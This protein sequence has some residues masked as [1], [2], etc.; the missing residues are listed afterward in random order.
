MGRKVIGMARNAVGPTGSWIRHWGGLLTLA[1]I[2]A[3]GLFFVRT[4]LA[5]HDTGAFELDGNALT[6]STH[7]W[8]KV[9]NDHLTNPPGSTSGANAISF[10]S[11]DLLGDG[12]SLQ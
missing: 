3:A 4:V 8:D 11:D 6:A 9:Y 7:D 12:P 2:V 5:V 1:I 10:N